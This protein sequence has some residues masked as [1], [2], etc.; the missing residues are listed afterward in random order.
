MLRPRRQLAA[1]PAPIKVQ[2]VARSQPIPDEQTFR[3]LKDLIDRAEAW[4]AAKQ[5]T[6]AA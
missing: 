4:K 2:L 5:K 6:E 3:W 1:V